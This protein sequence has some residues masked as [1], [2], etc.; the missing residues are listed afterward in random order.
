MGN[1]TSTVTP[2][3]SIETI[4]SATRV[5]SNNSTWEQIDIVVK[6]DT[7]SSDQDSE[8]DSQDDTALPSQTLA[9]QT[10]LTDESTDPVS[11]KLNSI[12]EETQDLKLKYRRTRS[13]KDVAKYEEL[14]TQLLL[15]LD[16]IGVTG[17]YR[18]V[19]KEHACVIDRLL[20]RVDELKVELRRESRINRIIN[21]SAVRTS[22]SVKKHSD[23][24]TKIVN[25]TSSRVAKLVTDT[26]IDT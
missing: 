24:I 7:D 19:R 1:N 9:P 12:K 14:L 8:Q 2:M 18:A 17:Q 25:A 3:E 22:R 15:K 20:S 10:P 26:H 6:Q 5:T 11:I 13:L 21:G 23:D 4:E 16:A